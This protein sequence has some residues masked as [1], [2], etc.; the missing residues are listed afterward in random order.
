MATWWN[1]NGVMLQTLT[2]LALLVVT[3]IYV[4]VT[5][6]IARATKEQAQAAGKQ[7]HSAEQQL[8][9][10]QRAL[11][12][13][14]A[15][16]EALLAQM[17]AELEAQKEAAHN[18]LIESAKARLSAL[19]PICAVL[20]GGSPITQH[21]ET[22]IGNVEMEVFERGLIMVRLQFKV[23]NDG[24]SPALVTAMPVDIPDE[25]LTEIPDW[26]STTKD[27]VLLGGSERELTFR[28]VGPGRMFAKW[29]AQK[30]RVDFEFETTSPISGVTD[31]H[32]WTGNFPPIC[33]VPGSSG[34]VFDHGANSGFFGPNA[35]T[36]VR[37]WPSG[38]GEN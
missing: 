34:T 25:E 21:N 31:R 23:R 7:A 3:A 15:A 30:R 2:T 28:I 33:D 24:S 12:A 36:L 9:H 11:D 8:D 38:F 22:S 20:W 13:E 10:A 29:A 1:R 27:E 37:I 16:S 18:V 17:T 26:L 14:K 5:A 32:T 19:T 35:A 6:R 4:W